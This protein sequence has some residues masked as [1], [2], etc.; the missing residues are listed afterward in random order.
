MV[1]DF[2][3]KISF[4]PVMFGLGFASIFFQGK[5]KSGKVLENVAYLSKFIH[6]DKK[7]MFIC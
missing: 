3:N 5:K 4:K 2:T 1:L 6:S 7:E